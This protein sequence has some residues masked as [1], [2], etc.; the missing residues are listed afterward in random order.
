[1]VLGGAEN[2][3]ENGGWVGLPG[4]NERHGRK[5]DEGRR[6]LRPCSEC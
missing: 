5:V 3:S 2:R 1:M 6:R 4:D